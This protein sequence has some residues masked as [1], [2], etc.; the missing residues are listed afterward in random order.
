MKLLMDRRRFLFSFSILVLPST[1]LAG[2]WS[3]ESFDNDGALDWV[4]YFKQKPTVA[5]L[6][7]TLELAVNSK[8]IDHFAGECTIAAAE[9]VAA[10]LGRPCKSFPE[11][12]KPFIAN[13]RI[14]DALL[15]APL[16]RAALSSVLDNK[17]E[18]RRSWSLH[19]EDLAIWKANVNE[20]QVRLF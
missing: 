14:D 13:I 20:L 10:C 5:F 11:D 8:Y 18:L 4:E 12:L 9:V 7:E 1:T 15:L 2:A 19:A 3:H 6:Y 16:A 17:S